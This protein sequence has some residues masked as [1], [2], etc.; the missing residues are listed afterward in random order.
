MAY[1]PRWTTPDK[2]AQVPNREDKPN[3]GRSDV[4]AALAEPRLAATVRAHAVRPGCAA[5]TLPFDTAIHS[6]CQMLAHSLAAHGDV[7]RAVSQYFSVALQQY[8]VVGELIERLFERPA[9]IEV[10]DFACG[11]G[12]LLRFLV[13]DL[14]PEQIHAAEIQRPA[15]DWVSHRHGVH[16]LASGPRPEDF[17]PDQRFDLIWVASLFSHLPEALFER[18]LGRLNA[19]LKP[20]GVLCFSVH[21]EALLPTGMAVG[22][23]GIHYIS[24]SENADLDPSIYGTSF[25]SAD[26]VKRAA[27]SATGSASRLRRLPRLLAHEQDVYVL[28]GAAGPPL[29]TLDHF[30][31]GAR[32][33]IDEL[34]LDHSDRSLWLRGWAGSMDGETMRGLE[35]ELDGRISIHPITEPSPQVA[36]VLGLAHLG[37]SGF[38]FTLELPDSATPWLRVS[39]LTASGERALIY[40]G[41]L[42]AA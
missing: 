39:A 40:A 22:Q 26:F 30:P 2:P 4:S 35:I 6:D 27:A 37:N 1:L 19:L 5:R 13:H 32:G 20:G 9:Q 33:W 15:L 3:P 21:D 31:R 34:E 25:V 16:T 7:N 28:S 8:R 14:P 36:E 10:L 24:G 41:R 23:R 42:P 17:Q 29:E 18:W 11:F 12:R 38:S